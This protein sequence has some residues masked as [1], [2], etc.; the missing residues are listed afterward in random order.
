MLLFHFTRIIRSRSSIQRSILIMCSAVLIKLV[1]F[2]LLFT[3]TFLPIR[4]FYDSFTD[5]DIIVY[6]VYVVRNV[7]F[8][9]FI[10]AI[11]NRLGCIVVRI[12][13][14]QKRESWF[15]LVTI[16]NGRNIWK[17]KKMIKLLL[18]FQTLH[19]LTHV[20]WHNW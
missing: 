13:V 19:V 7:V 17:L 18:F 3:Q 6:V 15:V 14:S 4:L 12:A 1:V 2:I 5:I 16:N 10:V 9:V 11:G 20:L 8:I